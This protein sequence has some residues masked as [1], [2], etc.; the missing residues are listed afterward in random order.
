MANL[1]YVNGFA[2]HDL[3]KLSGI[4]SELVRSDGDWQ[5]WT[6]IELVEALRKWTEKNPVPSTEKFS[7]N[8]PKREREV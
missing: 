6:Y 8:N 3:D 1:K 2:R 4:R 5:E 7:E